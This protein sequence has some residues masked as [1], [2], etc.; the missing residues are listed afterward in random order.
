MQDAITL[1]YVLDKA[2][3]ILST[4]TLCDNCLGR[5]FAGLGRGLS[6]EER[7]RSIKVLLAMEI[8]RLLQENLVEVKDIPPKLLSSIQPLADK[9]LES[10]GAP[11]PVLEEDTCYICGNKIKDFINEFAEEAATRLTELEASSFLIGVRIPQEMLEKENEI[12]QRFALKYTES[13]KNEIKRE[14]GKQVQSLTGLKPD[15]EEP[16]VVLLVDLGTMSIY[17]TINPIFLKGRYKKLAR[18]IS[19]SIWVTPKGKKYPLSVEE[20]LNSIT[21]ELGASRVVLHAAG[22]E[23][24]DARMLCKGRPFVIEVKRP[25]RRK[26]ESLK[27]LEAKINTRYK[28]L[29]EVHLEDYASRGLVHRYKDEVARTKKKYKALIYSEEPLVPEE[30]KL[31]ENYF[32]KNNGVIVS[33][34]TPTRVLHR[35]PDI[36][37][38]RRVYGVRI[39][40]IT[41][42]VIEALIHADGGLYI[43]ELIN[44][45]NGRTKPSFSEM[46]GKPLTCLKLDVIEVTLY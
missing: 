5:L 30:L 19:Q 41:S 22:R 16:D 42:N 1:T 12:S 7:G 13:I 40:S 9:I 20:A 15:F 31:L 36:V 24:V 37:R 2:Y 35:R 3:K 25:T 33:Q 43:K 44:G 28:Y 18:N 17:P 11:R 21:E 38:K 4:Y 39:K 23:D 34:R 29:V 32:S 10:L 46:L 27:D 45:D 14:I 8:H 6:N 26:I